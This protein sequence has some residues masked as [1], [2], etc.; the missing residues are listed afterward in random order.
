MHAHWA[1]AEGVHD[2][3]AVVELRYGVEP[4][5]ALLEARRVRQKVLQ[6]VAPSLREGADFLAPLPLLVESSKDC[7]QPQSYTGGEADR[8]LT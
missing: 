7:Y 5:A 2:H 6:P 1:A 3:N 8:W 4:G